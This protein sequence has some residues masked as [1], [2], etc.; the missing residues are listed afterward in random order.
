LEV[1]ISCRGPFARLA[2]QRFY[3][4]VF[5][6]TTDDYAGK[7]I[8]DI[9]CGPRGSLEWANMAE[10]RVGLD[11]LADKYMKLGAA[12]HKMTYVASPSEQIPFPD[13]HFDIVTSFNSLDHVDDLARTIHE[14]KR[15]AKP[16]GRFL[17]IV[18]ID[19]PP[20][21][22]EPLTLTKDILNSFAPEFRPVKHWAVRHG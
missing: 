14:I 9:G 3:T 21:P 11:P 10:E 1:T 4:D 6:L 5:G 19:H 7:K 18:E 17:L 20:T 22:T 16:N 8:L 12:N 15:V 2:F 13:G